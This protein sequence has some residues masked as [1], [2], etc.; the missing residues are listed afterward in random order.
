M[1]KPQ[2]Q[3]AVEDGVLRYK[4]A[5]LNLAELGTPIPVPEGAEPQSLGFAFL[6]VED[7]LAVAG[8]EAAT[9]V[10]NYGATVSI[11][12]QQS[13]GQLVGIDRLD[14]PQVGFF[15]NDFASE[16]LIG[17][18]NRLATR[19]N[20]LLVN[21]QF[22]QQRS[23]AVGD[24]LAITWKANVSQNTGVDWKDVNLTVSTGDPTLGAVKPELGTW[25]LDLR[26]GY[27]YGYK[28]GGTK[29]NIQK[30]TG[31][32]RDRQTGESLPYVN[33][34]VKNSSIGTTT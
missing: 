21:Q 5:D 30:V 33:V 2:T 16:P 15:R 7:H 10:G 1:E 19:R 26:N 14:W 29:G 18:L 12:G 32:V 20:G 6:P 13:S 27:P 3:S 23:L 31:W 34:K 25:Y 28:T 17:L 11:G 22:M 4:V 24:P 9:R 8:V